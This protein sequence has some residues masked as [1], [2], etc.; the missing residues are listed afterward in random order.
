MSILSAIGGI[1]FM[2][3]YGSATFWLGRASWPKDPA[4]EW[5]FTTNSA[6][7]IVCLMVVAFIGTGAIWAFFKLNGSA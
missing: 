2:L 5:H 4:Y 3:L 7:M 1:S 6:R